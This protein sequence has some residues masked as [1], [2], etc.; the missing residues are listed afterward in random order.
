ME[1]FPENEFEEIPTDFEMNSEFPR[2]P[3]D[4][5]EEE[6]LRELEMENTISPEEFFGMEMKGDFLAEEEF[7]PEPEMEMLE[8][9]F[10]PEIEGKRP[11]FPPVLSKMEFLMETALDSLFEQFAERAEFSK[12]LVTIAKF[13]EDQLMDAIEKY[14]SKIV[15]DLDEFLEVLTDFEESIEEEEAKIEEEEANFEEEEAMFKEEQAMF[16]E[17]QANFE[18]EQFMIEE[19]EPMRMRERFLPLKPKQGFCEEKMDCF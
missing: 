9:E 5:L 2:L 8:E 7:Y 11:P 17:E 10:D 15:G 6:F 3:E 16:E 12:M 1:A 19:E 4:E 14:F 13:S 18:E